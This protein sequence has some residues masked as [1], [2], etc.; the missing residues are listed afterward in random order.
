MS[1]AARL[2]SGRMSVARTRKWS[3]GR[4]RRS[5]ALRRSL[6]RRPSSRQSRSRCVSLTAA[7]FAGVVTALAPPPATVRCFDHP[8]KGE[9]RGRRAEQREALSLCPV[10]DLAG[11]LRFVVMTLRRGD[12]PV[13]ADRPLLVAADSHAI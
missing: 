11:V 8:C 3:R 9:Q 13:G 10:L 4:P 6:T 7:G 1:V 2:R 5:G 12:E